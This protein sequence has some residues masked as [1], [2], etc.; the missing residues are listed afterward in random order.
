M[1]IN[2][3]RKTRY[4]I[5]GIVQTGLGGFNAA[6]ALVGF[7]EMLTKFEK[8]KEFWEAYPFFAVCAAI[9]LFCGIRNLIIVRNCAM[10]NEA[11]EKDGEG[12]V[13][14][15]EISLRTGMPKK[16]I[17]KRLQLL[18][19]KQCLVNVVINFTD[20]EGDAEPVV[21]LED[22]GASAFRRSSAQTEYMVI[23]C[24][25]CGGSCSVKKGTITKCRFCGGYIK[26]N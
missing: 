8:V 22:K 6:V 1:Y 26:G 4:G 3:I 14:V 23:S 5:F 20:S 16:M 15:A 21:V 9:L 17:L 10:F 7:L 18:I 13:T 2:R 19:K 24:P 25:N 12:V 11:F